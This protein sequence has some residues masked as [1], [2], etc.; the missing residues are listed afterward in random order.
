[1]LTQQL[2]VDYVLNQNALNEIVPK[3]NEMARKN[4]LIK[5]AAHKTHNTV[6]GMLGKEKS[7]TPVTNPDDGINNKKQTNSGTIGVKFNLRDHDPKSMMTPSQKVKSTKP[8]LKMNTKTM[9]D[10]QQSFTMIRVEADSWND[11]ET[12]HTYDH[13]SDQEANT[14]FLFPDFSSESDPDEEDSLFSTE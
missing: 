13:S 14:D 5:Q 2:T 9:T 6:A 12:D 11:T 8:I 7:K 1:M 3:L 4:E 10:D